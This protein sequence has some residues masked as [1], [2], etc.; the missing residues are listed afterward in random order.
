MDDV[1]A[2]AVADCLQ[3]LSHVVAVTQVCI[4]CDTLYLSRVA[5]VVALTLIF[6]SDTCDT[7]CMSHVVAAA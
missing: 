4:T 1:V 7:V 2:M 3:Y 6:I 5:C